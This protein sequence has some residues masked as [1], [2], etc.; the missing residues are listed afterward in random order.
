MRALIQKVKIVAEKA[1]FPYFCGQYHYI[2]LGKIYIASSR[3]QI[4]IIRQ[5]HKAKFY[6]AEYKIFERI[7]SASAYDKPVVLDIGAN[8]GY[9]T[10]SYSL[11]LKNYNGLCISFEPVLK[12]IIC[13]SK[14]TSKLKNISLLSVAL[15]DNQEPLTLGIPAYVSDVGKDVENTGFL[16]AKL[17]KDAS[18]ESFRAASFQLD[19]ISNSLCFSDEHIVFLKLMLRVLSVKQ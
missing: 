7:I 19:S 13:F 5:H 3:R 9:T 2:T 15:G 4:K 16:S 1:V 11:I 17:N 18:C 12:N 14:N 10:V 6:S 8:V